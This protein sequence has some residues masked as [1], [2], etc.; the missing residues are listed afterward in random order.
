MARFSEVTASKPADE[1]EQRIVEL[2]H[3]A[4]ARLLVETGHVPEAVDQYQAIGQDSPQ[5]P[6]ALY[7]MAWAK[8]RAEDWE[9]ARNATDILLLVAPDSP[10]APEAQILQGHL[11]LKLKRYREATET[12]NG[13]ITTYAPVRDEIDRML[14]VQKDPVAY[15]DNLLARNER[16]LDVNTLLPPLAL[17]WASTQDDVAQA[18][19][20]VSSLEGGRQGVTESRAIAERI[21]KA[22]DER[23]AEA[24]PSLQEGTTRAQAVA[25]ALSSAEATLDAAEIDALDPLLTHEERLELGQIQAQLSADRARLGALPTTPAELTARRARMQ[26]RLDAMDREAFR[27][28]TDLQS[29]NAML[30]ATQK[31]VADTRES[32]RD[33]PEDEKQFTERLVSEQRSLKA[34]EQEVGKLRGQL[35]ADRG[36][37][38]TTLSGED[39]IRK[40][41]AA[42]SSRA[43]GILSGVEPRATGDAAQFVRRSTDLRAQ[44]ATLEQRTAADQVGAPRAGAAEGRGGPGEGPRRGEAARRVRQGRGRRLR[45]RPAAGGADGLR[46]LPA[47]APAVLR[48]GAQ[49]RRGRGGHRLHQEAV[50][51]HRHPEGRLAEGGGAAGAGRGLPA[52]PQGR[53]LMLGPVLIALALAG[54]PRRC[55]SDEEG[56]GASPRRPPLRL[57]RRP[58]TPRPPPRRAPR[59][60]SRTSPPSG[61]PRSGSRGWAAPPPSRSSSTSSRRCSAATRPSRASSSTTCSCWWRRSTRRSGATSP[62]ATRRPSATSR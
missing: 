36:L 46:Q 41:M 54:E 62:P 56:E 17:K 11:L 34:L 29:M 44:I 52:G 18:L 27:L 26:D 45:R 48:P 31:W 25:N 43:R 55:H 22:L 50:P 35:L 19:R 57:P 20:V 5:F 1:R 53:G 14:A 28:G 10:L 40:E 23:G 8:V 4:L 61:S 30:V 12:Y 9:G 47:G 42:A 7:E 2:A 32:R 60:R 16:T 51:D 58:P 38:D 15:F 24:F 21:L 59:P 39:A 3:L 49:G 37:V 6:E 33:G 13:V